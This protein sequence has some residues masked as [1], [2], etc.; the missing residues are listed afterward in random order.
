MWTVFVIAAVV[1]VAMIG[2][3]ELLR[4]VWLFLLRPKDDPQRLIVVFLKK[5]IALQQLRSALEYIS[6]DGGGHFCGVVAV[7]SDIDGKEKT[8][9]LNMASKRGDIFFSPEEYACITDCKKD[10]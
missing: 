10:L 6:W 8:D 9:I 1:A 4:R 5:D 2:V 3:T 7:T